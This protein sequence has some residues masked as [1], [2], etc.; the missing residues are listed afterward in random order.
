M[1]RPSNGRSPGRT[2][3]LVDLDGTLV[4]SVP[5]LAGA[6]NALLAEQGSD[7][8]PLERIKGMV[9]EGVHKLVERA[10]D[11][12]R[13]ETSLEPLVE[14]FLTLY[15]R[16]LTEETR[17]YPKAVEILEGLKANGWRLALCT[18]KPIAFSRAILRALDLDDLFDSAAGGDS[19][20][21]RKPDPE[22]L[23]LT[24]APLGLPL[25]RAVMLGDGPADLQAAAAAGIPAIWCRF[26]YGGARTEGLPRAAEI[27]GFEELPAALA[28][29]GYPG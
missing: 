3:L 13:L 29:L 21:V 6:L 27:D 14:R 19:F 25:S 18:N 5:D 28:Q 26:G 1:I 22:H 20:P 24:L 2:A 23:R 9:G 8:L 7:R 15:G 11:A 10:A 16:R 12:C 17:P 4:D